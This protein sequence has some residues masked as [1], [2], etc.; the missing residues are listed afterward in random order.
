[1]DAEGDLDLELPPIAPAPPLTKKPLLNHKRT[2]DYD[3]GITNSSDP[4]VFSSDDHVSGSL[5]DYTSKRRKYQ[6]KGTW[7]GERTKRLSGSRHRMQR[8]FKRNYDSGIFMGSETTESSLDEE[9]L[10][11]IRRTQDD[12]LP[13][14]LVDETP[15]SN[16]GP[17]VEPS[18]SQNGL[19][20]ARTAPVRNPISERVRNIVYQCL[21]DGNE[22]IDLS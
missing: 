7:W 1:M 11:D 9:F 8:E 12:R 14:S 13:E 21:D 20:V 22:S 5:D 19:P 2:W 15:A 10:D 18:S 3:A 6:W 16:L 17:E 4:A